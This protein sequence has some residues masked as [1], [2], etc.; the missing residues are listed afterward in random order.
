MESSE[1]WKKNPKTSPVALLTSYALVLR[2]HATP[3]PWIWFLQVYICCGIHALEKRRWFG[4]RLM[5]SGGLMVFV[6]IQPYVTDDFKV[7]IVWCSR[8]YVY[9]WK[10]ESWSKL[11]QLP[12]AIGGSLCRSGV[13]VNIGLGWTSRI[14]LKELYI[15]IGETTSSRCC[16][17]RKA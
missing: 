2:L 1:D 17:S 9:S 6:V 8:Y 10:E 12:Y 5:V 16:R 13:S 3:S 15:L 4:Q 11:K 7:V 14:I